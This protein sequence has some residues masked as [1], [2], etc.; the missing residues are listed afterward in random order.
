MKQ[1]SNKKQQR[2]ENPSFVFPIS[3]NLFSRYFHIDP[4]ILS[5]ESAFKVCGQFI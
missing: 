4:L 2:E 5:S 3:F 1:T